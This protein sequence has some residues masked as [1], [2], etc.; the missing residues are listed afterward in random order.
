MNATLAEPFDIFVPKNTPVA[1]TRV[2]RPTTRPTGPMAQP[3]FSQNGSATQRLLEWNSRHP[4]STAIKAA[5]SNM[6]ACFCHN[7]ASIMTTEQICED[8]WQ[9]ICPSCGVSGP[10]S[11]SA[12]LA[13][14]ATISL[15]T[16]ET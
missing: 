12:L 1:I 4:P 3:T 14:A 15:F 5:E 10:R 13:L 9:T 11:K 7:C 16:P 6:K 2:L 8:R